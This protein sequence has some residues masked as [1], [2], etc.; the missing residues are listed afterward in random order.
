MCLLISVIGKMERHTKHLHSFSRNSDESEDYVGYTLS[1]KKHETVWQKNYL[2]NPNRQLHCWGR[3]HRLDILLV[4][5]D[6]R[7]YS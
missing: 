2:V 7:L 5:E 6:S 4:R 3:C 1:R